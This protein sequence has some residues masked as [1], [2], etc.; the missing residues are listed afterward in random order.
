MAFIGGLLVLGI[1]LW[2]TLWAVL[3]ILRLVWDFLTIDWFGID[4]E[5]PTSPYYHD[6]RGQGRGHH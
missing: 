1:V 5:D 3:I 4:Y 6:R 2:F